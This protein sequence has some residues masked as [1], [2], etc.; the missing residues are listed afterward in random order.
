[1]LLSLIR[2]Y[3]G[4]LGQLALERLNI[5]RLEGLGLWLWTCAY[6]QFMDTPRNAIKPRQNAA[7]SG[8]CFQVADLEA[9]AG[10]CFA[11]D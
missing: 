8:S 9:A 5:G 7:N 10:R 6:T 11:N 4:E 1:M 2:L 3:H